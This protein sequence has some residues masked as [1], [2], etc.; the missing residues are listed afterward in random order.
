MDLGHLIDAVVLLLEFSLSLTSLCLCWYVF[1][2]III[3]TKI[4]TCYR[5]DN[6]MNWSSCCSWKSE[7][8]S[9]WCM[10]VM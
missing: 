3:T 5:S 9:R 2:V 8:C 6:K 7:F 1:A 10:L 4:I